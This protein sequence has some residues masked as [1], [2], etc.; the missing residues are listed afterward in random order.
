MHALDTLTHPW[1]R[2]TAC[3][4]A[5]NQTGRYVVTF[6]FVKVHA[7][8]HEV[9]EIESLANGL[10]DKAFRQQYGVVRGENVQQQHDR[11]EYR[12]FV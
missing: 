3:Y 6:G 8:K 1:C 5:G 2:V 10:H 4:D 7:E 9:S 12:F 11:E